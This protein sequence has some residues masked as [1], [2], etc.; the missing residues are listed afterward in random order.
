MAKDS[1][2][3]ARVTSAPRMVAVARGPRS[4]TPPEK[5]AVIVRYLLAEGASIPLSTL[6]DQVQTAL[7]EQMGQMSRIDRTT[8]DAV[9]D[10]FV[11]ELEQLGLS[12]SGGLDGA[13]A[14]MGSH[15]S[16]NAASRLRRIANGTSRADPWDRLVTL[17]CDLLLPVLEQES[18]EVAAVMLSKLPVPKAAELLGK[19][20]GDKARRVAYAVSLTGNVDPDTVQRIGHSLAQQ[21]DQQPL[22]AFE[23]GA[24]ERIGAILNISPTLTRDAVLLGLEEDD[25]DFAEQV[26]RAIFTFVHIPARLSPR[27]VPKLVRIVE[28]PALVTALAASQAM[29]DQLAAA[30]FLL[31]NMSQRVAQGL[32]DDMAQRGKIKE[33]DAEDAKSMIVQAI[34]QL[35]AAGEVVLISEDD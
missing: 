3:L 28:Q 8:L 17:S 33:K 30:E 6:P 20:P 15:L 25:A 12:F 4:L 9:L 18:T 31:A 35:E 13:L 26:R 29:P 5:A 21:L 19:L 7:A 11:D 23:V 32:R 27:D 10:E 22:K 2:A 24:V 14:V 16:P 34:R 1:T